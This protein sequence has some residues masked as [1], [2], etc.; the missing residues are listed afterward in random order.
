MSRSNKTDITTPSKRFFQWSG[1]EGK[2]KY[3]DRETKENVFVELPFTF[4]VLDRLVTIT[5]YSDEDQS[6]FWSNEI[7]SIQ[8]ETLTIRTSKGIR[9]TGLYSEVKSIVGAKF[10]QSVYIGFYDENK[11]LQ[12]GNFKFAGSAVS[13]WIE[14]SEGRDV[15]SGAIRIA[16]ANAEKKGATKYFSP[17]F[18]P[19]T[20]ISEATEE[21]AKELDRELQA[22]LT[23]YFAMRGLESP[24]HE[25][26]NGAYIDQ[27]NAEF[28]PFEDEEMPD[29]AK[30]R[31][32]IPF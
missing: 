24:Q 3:Y 18:E 19:V 6:G 25:K 32:E 29:W 12:I 9:Q 21:S 17:V 31:D 11:V 16:G 10:A 26:G 27:R 8:N 1:S 20:N 14:F 13:S 28:E 4:L 2:I 15:E 7:R 22:Y 30:E 23:A 5:G